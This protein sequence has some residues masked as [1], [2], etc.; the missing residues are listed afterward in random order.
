MYLVA[1]TAGT[2]ARARAKGTAGTAWA[3]KAGAL[4][5]AAGAENGKTGTGMVGITRG[6]TMVKAAVDCSRDCKDVET[7]TG[8]ADDDVEV[9][10]GKEVNGDVS[11]D[12][13]FES[14]IGGSSRKLDVSKRL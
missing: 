7:M 12:G 14:T 5:T 6:A 2:G 10:E 3:G 1:I 8:D 4:G 13:T 11:S 9:V